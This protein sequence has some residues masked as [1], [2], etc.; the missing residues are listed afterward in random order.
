MITRV[1][2]EKLT[3]AAKESNWVV[4][5]VTGKNIKDHLSNMEEF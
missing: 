5:L 1:S 4:N 3:A 2:Y